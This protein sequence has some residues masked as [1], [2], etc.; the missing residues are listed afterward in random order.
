MTSEAIPETRL[1]DLKVWRESCADT[2]HGQDITARFRSDEPPPAIVIL[3]RSG[4]FRGLLSRPKFNELMA[5][6]FGP[7]LRQRRPIGGLLDGIEDDALLLPVTTAIEAA[8]TRALSRPKEQIYEPFAV[9]FDDGSFGAIETLDL[10]QALSRHLQRTV[11]TLQDTQAELVQ[12]EKM[13]ALGSLVAGVAHEVST[14][15][16][17]LLGTSSLC[18]ELVADLRQRYAGNRLTGA[19]LV[20]GLDKLAE[21]TALIERNAGRAAELVH[22]F[23]KVAVDYSSSQ[24][25]RFAL[26]PYLEDV[27]RSIGPRFRARPIA[28]SVSC[29]DEI[30][31]DG[32]PGPLAQALINLV[33]NAYLHAFDETG[34]GAIAV[35]ATCSGEM[36][37]VTVADDGRGIDPSL[38]SKV[39]EPFY[40]TRRG[41]GGSG[42]G[43]H[44]VYNLAVSVLAGSIS[45]ESEPGRGSAFTLR[46]PRIHPVAS[47]EMI[48]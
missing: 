39:F 14:P 42:L 35:S 17:I 15:V 25:R 48:R 11:A 45:V 19:A 7:E 31:C 21:A 6:P 18:G 38:L 44:V 37:A 43:L 10:L 41:E 23:K 8:A 46:F 47:E 4:G 3:N 27:L 22:G 34:E 28:L 24:R 20:A 33:I 12:A 5:R 13:A 40:T 1:S 32:Y 36:V 30:E 16:G 2:T 9:A 26:G 29:P